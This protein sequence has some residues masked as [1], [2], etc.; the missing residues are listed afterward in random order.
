MLLAGLQALGRCG[1]CAHRTCGALRTPRG[2]A[3]LKRDLAGLK[4]YIA[5]LGRRYF[6]RFRAEAG[7]WLRQA[8]RR[9]QKTCPAVKTPAVKTPPAYDSPEGPASPE[10]ATPGGVGSPPPCSPPPDVA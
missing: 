5:F 3:T 4:I 2:R 7:R 1:R 10:I 8:W 9:R 6:R